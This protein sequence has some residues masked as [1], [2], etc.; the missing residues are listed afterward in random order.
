[1]LKI[2]YPKYA[3]AIRFSREETSIQQVLFFDFL[4][5]VSK[6]YPAFKVEGIN[7]EKRISKI[8]TKKP[9]IEM[10]TDDSYVEIGEYE[11]KTRDVIAVGISSKYAISFES[12]EDLT[13]SKA[14]NLYTVPILSLTEHYE[15][16]I[17]K[18]K[19][20][21]KAHFVK[22]PTKVCFSVRHHSNFIRVTNDSP[23]VN[24]SRVEYP[25]YIIDEIMNSFNEPT[26][27]SY[28]LKSVTVI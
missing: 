19:A 23:V 6:V 26:R 16:I 20:F 11:S 13:L 18:I 7:T 2:K 17:K 22:R 12:L 14:C 1:M 4:T 21:I 24:N 15:L 10:R 25:E 5:Q 27:T 8:E 9:L 28:N 3:F